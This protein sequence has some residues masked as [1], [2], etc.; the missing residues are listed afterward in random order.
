[1]CRAPPEGWPQDVEMLRKKGFRSIAFLCVANSARSQLAEAI[2][3]HLGPPTVRVYSAGSV[4]TVVRPEVLA[5]LTEL[6]IDASGLK[7]KGLAEIPLSS[8]D[9]VITLCAAEQCPLAVSSGLVLHWELADPA[10][11]DGST[12]LAG[13]RQTRDELRRR[14]KRLF[15]TAT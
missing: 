4:P 12:N 6:G 11:L 13:F 7:S 10:A 5:V 15:P 3:R 14:I 8:V 9:V 1:M 2:A